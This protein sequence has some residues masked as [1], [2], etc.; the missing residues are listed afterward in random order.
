M[1]GAVAPNEGEFFSLVMPYTNTDCMNVFLSELS[2]AYPNQS[3]LLIVDN[4][5]WHHAKALEIPENIELFSLLPY[6]P[7]LNPIKMIWEELREKGFRNEILPSLEKVV[8]RL[9]QVVV[10]LASDL[11]RVASIPHRDWIDLAFMF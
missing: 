8:D 2:K 1:Y 6:T 11:T 4:A 5:A 10:T 7:E 9:C 3:I